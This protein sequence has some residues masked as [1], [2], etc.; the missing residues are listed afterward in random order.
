MT[1][2]FK[3]FEKL[4]QSLSKTKDAILGRISEVVLGRK[5]D[6]GV[7]DEIEEVL[8]T[9][10]VGVRATDRLIGSL[11]SAVHR[12]AVNDSEALRNLLKSEMI[13]ILSGKAPGAGQ[14]APAALEIWM[15]TGVNGVGKTTTI[16]KLA[17]H[18]VRSGKSV[19]IG[20]CD[21]F[22]AAAIDQVAIWAE[23]SGVAMIRAH[24]GADPSSVA[25]DAA[26]AARARGVDLLLIDTAGRLHTKANLMDELSKMKRVI[27]KAA[28]DARMQSK[29]IVDGTTGQNALQQVTVFT[30]AVG[31]DGLIVTKL[32]GTAKGGFVIAIAEDLGVPIDFVGV[33]EGLD[34]LEPFDPRQ[35]VDAL[36]AA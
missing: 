34:D 26:A 4:R 18:F 11:R 31:C 10:D 25:F 14:T 24:E 5:I 33:G 2:L 27:A 36:F 28:P 6:D 8:L 1:A 35:F 19:M 22:R 15:I 3:A 23:R 9:A 17:A 16:G 32:D 12:G 30:R 20:A 13:A 7:I 29:L 21:T